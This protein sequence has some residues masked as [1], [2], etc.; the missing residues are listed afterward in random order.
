MCTRVPLT[1]NGSLVRVKLLGRPF[2]LNIGHRPVP[3]KKFLKAWPKWITAICGAFLVMSS[4]HGK[5]S[6]LRALSRRRRAASDGFGNVGSSF[7][8]SYCCCHWY[9]A[10]CQPSSSDKELC[11][12]AGARYQPVNP[13]QTIMWP[14]NGAR[15]LGGIQNTV[16]LWENNHR[17]LPSGKLASIAG[18]RTNRY[19]Q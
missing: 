10:I 3:A 1:A 5:A 11:T 2:F 15:K 6:R 9:R 16:S 8:A 7:H 4:I 13:L 17:R 12:R 14:G 19:E 18:A